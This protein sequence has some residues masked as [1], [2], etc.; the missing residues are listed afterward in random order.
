MTS[1][2]LPCSGPSCYLLDACP[3][4]DTEYAEYAALSRAGIVLELEDCVACAHQEFVSAM[5]M[6][7]VRRLS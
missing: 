7:G 2:D 5:D 4:H 6:A 1:H 3:K